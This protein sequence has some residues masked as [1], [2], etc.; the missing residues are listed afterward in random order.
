MVWCVSVAIVEF[1][2]VAADGDSNVT[3]VVVVTTVVFCPCVADL[4][5]FHF[6]V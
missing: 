1:D 3:A 5:V 4:R 2:T 6:E